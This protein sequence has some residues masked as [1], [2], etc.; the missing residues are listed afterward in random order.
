[1]TDADRIKDRLRACETASEIEAV[2]SEEREA[3]KA[4]H[5]DGATLD[6]IGAE[7]GVTRARAQQ[8]VCKG[9]RTMRKRLGRMGV[10]SIEE[11]LGDG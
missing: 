7:L 5:I 8:I 11:A 2:A 4:M 10:G 6:E 3:V 9:L 1:M